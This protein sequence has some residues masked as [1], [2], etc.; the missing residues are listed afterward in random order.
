MSIDNPWIAEA[1]AAAAALAPLK[2]AR[3]AGIV[4]PLGR[5]LGDLETSPPKL[6]SLLLRESPEIVLERPIEGGDPGEEASVV[7]GVEAGS[8]E[9]EDEVDPL[10]ELEAREN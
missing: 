3:G 1:A 9:D 5:V 10:R 7:A 8:G 6:F 4:A 2:A